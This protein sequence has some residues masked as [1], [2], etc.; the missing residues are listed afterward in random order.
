MKVWLVL[1][2]AYNCKILLQN[3]M[4]VN[5]ILNQNFINKAGVQNKG[6]AHGRVSVNLEHC[7]II[8]S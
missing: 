1:V 7:Q 3:F 5:Q 4:M 2:R 8:I 6:P